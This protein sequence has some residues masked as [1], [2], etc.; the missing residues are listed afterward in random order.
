M[1]QSSW[2]TGVIKDFVVQSP[3]N[4]MGFDE[5][6][7]IFDTPLVGFSSGADPLYDEY[8]SHIGSFYFSPLELLAK[9]F[10]DKKL[11]AKDITVI[12]WIIPSTAATRKEQARQDRYPSE[13]WVRTR[14][15]GEKFNN[16]IRA[17]VVEQLKAAEHRCS[18][19]APLA[20]LG[21]IGRRTL[22]ALLKLV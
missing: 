4:D 10:P 14:D 12:S 8:K 13:R 7:K 22:C 15:M 2:I 18:G 6:E 11:T 19:P 3:L 9:T 21:Q 17:H 20:A 5:R 1:N 16:S